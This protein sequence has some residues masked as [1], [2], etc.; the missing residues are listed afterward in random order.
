MRLLLLT[1][2]V[3]MLHFAPV[4]I[5]Q[6]N[7]WDEADW[8]DGWDIEEPTGI[9]IY[10]FVEA[11]AGSR[12]SASPYHARL[13]LGEL[14]LRLG[15]DYTWRGATFTAKGDALYDEVINSWQTDIRELNLQFSLLDNLDLK[16]GRQ[17]LTWGTGD[18]LFLND[19]FPKD[20]Q[21]FFSGRDDEYLKAPSDAIKLSAYFDWFN[22][23]LAWTPK[24]DAD[25]YI[26]GERLS[27]FN[28]LTGSVGGNS[29]V[30][31][32]DQPSGDEVAIRLFKTVKGTEWALYGYDGYL[33]SPEALTPAKLPT[34]SRLRVWGGS[35]RRPFA[36]GIVNVEAAYHA[37]LDDP[38]GDRP[39][40][41][42]D[43][44]R[45]LVGYEQELMT[46]L[47]GGFQAYLEHTQEYDSLLAELPAGQPL[48]DENRVVLTSRLTWQ[49]EGADLTLSLFT[50]YSPTANDGYLR[51][52]LDYRLDDHWSFTT[53]LNL[54]FG[55]QRQTFFKQFND[56]NNLY[57]RVRYAF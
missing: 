29:V 50:F 41:P 1:L 8:E 55:E 18:Y 39:F 12:L 49:N 36:A 30:M 5:A 25:R 31:T 56:N 4:A 44:W 51:P 34:F 10:G 6:G 57:L 14:R 3:V 15:T 11:A 37:S 53:G 23:D 9:P 17:I 27:R 42:N 43:Q 47:T 46:R 13:S 16:A 45:L 40:V 33:K 28:P 20:W 19:L 35:M 26:S 2:T 52:T 54:F 7:G 24:F 32:V 48:P 38:R 22:I 21:S